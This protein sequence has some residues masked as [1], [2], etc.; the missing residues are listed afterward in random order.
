MAE[1]IDGLS[2]GL[3]LDT[4]KVDTGLKDLKSKL[5]MVNSEMKA[6]MSAFDRGEK[7]LSKYQTQL[8]GLNK[9]IEVQKAVTAA[10]QKN[11][12]KMVREHGEGSKE[13]E[14]AATQYNNQA[15]ALNNLERHVDGVTQEMKEF[16]EAQRVAESGFT[17]FGEKMESVGSKMQSVGAGMKDVG[18]S[19][20]MYVT[21][22][23]VG[24]GAVAAK[25]GI[26]FGDSMAKVQA[27]SGA[28]GKD[29]D[30]LR[31]K[32][33]EMGAKTK[34][35][36]SQSAEALNYMA[37]A[38][39]KTTD[40][41][42]GLEGVM[43]LAAA[44]GEDLGIVS[45]IVT[46]GLT[47]FGLSAKDSGRFADVLAAAS[48]NA[49]TNVGMLGKSFEYA[50]PVAG[51]LGYS[52]EDTAVAL[53]L[54]A[55]AGIKA[56]KG[57]TALRSMLTNLV[58]PNKRMT[59]I[60]NELNISLT[61]SSGN[62]KQL[63]EIMSDLRVGFGGLTEEQQASYA[64]MLF[65][66]EAMSGA[67][68]VINASETDYN[69]LTK[70][71]AGSTGAAKEMAD[72]MEGKLGGTI[73]EIKSGLEGFAISL[74]EEMEPS[75]VKVA[76]GIK[77][78][79]GWLNDLSPA[80]KK[81]A[82]VVGGIA[83]A[84][85][86][87]LVGLG[88]MTVAL[89]S[90]IGFIGSVSSAIGIMGTGV[91]AATPLIGGLASIFTVL[92]GPIGLTI[93]ALTGVGIGVTA[94][95]GHLKKDA[96][97]EIDRFGKEVSESTKE[98]LGSFF[99]LSD[100][101]SAELA[102]LSINSKTITQEMANSLS[103]KFKEMN[104]QITDN[105]KK[106]H[107][108]QIK[109]MESFF[110][111]SSALSDEREQ[112]I[113]NKQKLQ[114]QNKEVEQ[115][116]AE[117]RI[118]QILQN[119]ADQKR[120]LT[121]SEQQQ[122]NAIQQKMNE[123]AVVYLTENEREQKVILERMKA[124]ASEL[125]A[126]QAAAVVKES[127]KAR[128]EVIKD[129]DKKFND[130]VAFATKE[131]DETGS[132]SAKEA[133]DIINEAKKQRDESVK[134]AQNKH[135][136]VVTEA[137]KQAKE[138]V[139]EVNWETGE[140]KSK[141]EVM[142]TSVV[143]TA[144]KLGTDAKKAGSD[145]WTG[146][147]KDSSEGWAQTKLGWSSMKDNVV[148]KA[149]SMGA[150]V[151][152]KYND[153]K[154]NVVQKT[155]E[156]K[157]GVTNGFETTKNLVVNTAT[158]MKE[159][160]LSI[161][162]EIVAGAKAMPGK[163][164]DGI[165]S[166]AGLAVDGIKNV[167]QKMADKFGAIVNGLIGGLNSITKTLGVGGNIPKWNVPKFAYGT[168]SHKGGLMV[169]GDKFGREIVELPNGQSF[170][171]PDTDTLVNA[172]KGTRVI[173]NKITEQYLKG[174]IPHFA[175]GAGV[176]DWMKEKAVGLK[177]VLSNVWDYATNPSKL[178]DAMGLGSITGLAGGMA[179]IAKGAF[180]FV[181]GKAAEYLK[182]MFKKAEEL[183]GDGFGPPFRLNSRYGW[184][185]HPITGVKTFH[186]GDDWGAPSGTPIPNQVAGTVVNSG[187]MEGRG[188]YVRIKSGIMERIYQHNSRNSVRVGQSVGKGQTVG[189]VGSTGWST[190]PHLHYEVFKNGVNIDPQGFASGGYIGK[191]GMYNLAEEGHGEFVIPTDP[192]RRPDAMKLLA[193]AAKS[194]TGGGGNNVRPSGMSGN[195]GVFEEMVSILLEQ[196]KL[197]MQLL[198]K[199]TDVYLDG[200]LVGQGVYD[201]VDG[202]NYDKT[203][204][205]MYMRGGSL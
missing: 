137:Q 113:L 197:L 92:T 108:E 158:K 196:N 144:K 135:K 175:K 187:Y 107:G 80:A 53:G 34:F 184:R 49:N 36:A 193:L 37:M 66:K 133:Q 134:H 157:T 101:A 46:D 16:A 200:Q 129:A 161:F 18:K 119:A 77:G 69:K 45:D 189:L 122:I 70:A 169:V 130:V 128:D 91:A 43:D 182:N 109:E 41:L 72:I 117:E 1:R 149:T 40:M 32:A 203:S 15:A 25:T 65:G 116:H 201:T 73:R 125:S 150:S 3:S 6:N 167:G 39:W 131:R 88:T 82:L 84:I 5:T 21:A 99:E 178:I 42:D 62:M 50:A 185:I 23:L 168:D 156:M 44:S 152:S 38:G 111:N 123:T 87:V 199:N 148:E 20:S 31:E 177:S 204:A 13:A 143:D 64:A 105:M 192:K 118:Q 151:K 2:I 75:L 106:E 153:M 103:G 27:V 138:H 51:A 28:T 55:N 12:E 176:M 10:A 194:I 183:K 81:S 195:G 56:D 174:D 89:G 35:S 17:K 121:E 71:V 110:L 124:T 76:A 163:M 33:K 112:E 202:M 186:R 120:Q 132:I 61:D 162:T 19:M 127:A 147:K 100:G 173:P 104:K 4:I 48:A 52:V 205:A 68:A 24:F 47:A 154:S 97:P 90:V 180:G 115:R 79:V 94:L 98:A 188:N 136:D 26:D 171:S 102:D 74:Y 172:P 30:N 14:K 78:F 59:A 165:V 166:M 86:P 11:Y 164:K 159:R 60:M 190:G 126:K 96:I 181:K 140:I 93:A 7:S 58:T 160:A 141:W 54:M 67:L 170:I 146:I 139:K 63:D 179:N 8:D 142:K 145:M 155:A 95:V 29:L 85:G 22:P 114:N 57:G 9:K 191:S 83:A 198:Q